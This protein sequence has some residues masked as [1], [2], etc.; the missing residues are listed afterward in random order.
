MMVR[1]L[2]PKEM[3]FLP[4]T[5]Q[6]FMLNYSREFSDLVG[7]WMHLPSLGPRLC[8]SSLST[9][10]RDGRASKACHLKCACRGNEA[11]REDRSVFDNHFPPQ[12]EFIP[13]TANTRV[14]KLEANAMTEAPTLLGVKDK[15]SIFDLLR[16]GGLRKDPK[17]S[18]REKEVEDVFQAERPLVKRFYKH[19]FKAFGYE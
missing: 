7:A 15:I 3:Y 13:Q 2:H 9:I 12:V 17:Q 4:I 11:F 10:G 14:F 6:H 1:G 19:D 5:S 8:G 16:S 18:R